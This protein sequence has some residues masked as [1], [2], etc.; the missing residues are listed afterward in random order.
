MIALLLVMS[1]WMFCY[2][3]QYI[4][5]NHMGDLP[6]DQFDK[7]WF[8]LVFGL[9]TLGQVLTQFGRGFIAYNFALE[10]SAKLNSLGRLRL[11][12]VTNRLLHA[13]LNRFFH[14]NA[15]GKVL[16][17]LSGDIERVDRFLPR[18]LSYSYSITFRV[19]V[20]FIVI[21]VISTPLFLIFVFVYFFLVFRIQRYYSKTNIELTR[22]Q[23]ITRSPFFQ[24]FTDSGRP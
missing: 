23:S 10:V 16:N 17:R 24:L 19:L 13:S 14:K 9:I 4:F 1:C 15:V 2:G 7:K 21:S 3:Y 20:S 11:T 8:F 5:L 18:T 22:L 6:E 12:A